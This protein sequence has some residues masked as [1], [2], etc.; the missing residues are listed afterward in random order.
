[1]KRILA[2]LLS[3]VLLIA[4]VIPAFAGEESEK[5]VAVV[6]PG[7]M[8]TVLF[9]EDSL[10]SHLR[11]FDGVKAYVRDADNIKNLLFGLFKAFFLFKYDKLDEALVA[12]NDM[13]L[14][15]LDMNPDGTSVKKLCPV[16]TGAANCTIAALKSSGDWKHVD[17]GAMISKTLGEQLGDEN[18]FVFLYDW[19]LNP[20]DLADKLDAFIDEAKEISDVDK[21]NIYSNSYGAQIVS[22]YLYNLGGCANVGRVVFNAPAWQGTSL[23][24]LLTAE[25]KEDMHINII[26]G[27]H[28][29][30]RLMMYDY[31]LEPLV[32]LIPKRIVNE[33]FFTLAQRT[34]YAHML[35]MPAFWCCCASEDYE[36]LK[37]K[38][39]DPVRDADFIAK[40]DEVQYG[41]M[42]RIP[43][44][45]DS[46]QAQGVTVA[47]TAYDGSN[48]FIGDRINGDHVVN[49]EKA[50]G[51]E[52]ALL[53]EKFAD[54]RTGEHVSP[55]GGVDLT[56]GLL[57]DRT[58]VISGQ[59]HGQTYWDETT[60]TLIPKLLL[61]DEI[62]SVFSSPDYPQF[63][64]SRCPALDVSL[65]LESGMEKTLRPA[66]G[67]VKAI[68]T[69]DSDAYILLSGVT[70]SGLPYKSGPVLGALKP[71]ES[72]TFT[73]TPKTDSAESCCGSIKVCYTDFGILPQAESR[74]FAFKIG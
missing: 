42:T 6:V 15:N 32:R 53:G 63:M 5:Q 60:N 8:E 74:D 16:V 20:I 44:I 2:I 7:V 4:S 3:C 41:V 65:R 19:R 43:E 35:Y 50:A 18:V 27:L 55:S 40:N 66:D 73:L 25:N 48:L 37:A 31:D 33:V 11:Y 1:M 22:S 14:G 58:W 64:D 34:L 61:T 69:N 46:I 67:K 70:V 57:P 21:V 23:C 62:E 38:L 17:Q 10:D 52:A 59:A 51:G 54:G 36:D 45:L 24:R 26:D 47:I 9:F 68:I 29:V 28:F 49:I 12:L 39:L 71:G 13:A 72:K 30:M 56:N